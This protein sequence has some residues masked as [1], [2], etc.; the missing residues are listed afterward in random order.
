MRPWSPKLALMPMTIIVLL[1]YVGCIL[2][3]L[4]ISLTSSQSL[5]IYDF[6]GLSQYET[7]LRN[8][9]W[10]T[11]LQ[12]MF[13]FAGGYI[14]VCL[15]LGMLLAIF[16]DQRVRAENALRTIFLYPHAMS[17]IVTGLI[18]QWMLNPVF[19]IQEVVRNLGWETFRF[20]WLVN[21]D[22]AIYTLVLAGV[23]HGAGF[24]MAILLAGLRGVDAEIWRAT[25]IDGIPAWRTYWGIVLPMMTGVVM[26]STILLSVQAVKSYDVVVAMTGGGPGIATELPAK[27]VMDHM[28]ERANI[29]RA[30]A[31][32]ISMLM[33]VAAVVAPFLF[34]SNMRKTKG[35]TY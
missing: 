26:T 23:W 18:W 3:T 15:V 31:A 32:A 14:L 27:Y 13:I 22:M 4:R 9:R 5:P 33:I 30:A 28:F 2:W 35:A 10:Q 34:V 7:L 25:R 12:N 6:V 29:A 11:S 1:V 8:R 20:D 16:I 19:G 24:V 17:F 21:S